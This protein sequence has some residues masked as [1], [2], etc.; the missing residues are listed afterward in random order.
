MLSWKSPSGET[1]LKHPQFIRGRGFLLA[2]F[3]SKSYH[4]RSAFNPGIVADSQRILAIES[5]Q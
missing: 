1:V 5:G 2:L 3:D 4:S